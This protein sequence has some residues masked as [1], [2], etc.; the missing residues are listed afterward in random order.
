MPHSAAGMRVEPPVSV[1]MVISPMPSAQ[2]TAPPEDEPPG[3]RLRSAGLPGVPKCGLAPTPE[4]ANSVMLVLATITAPASRRRLTAGASAA[5]GLPRLR[6]HRRACARHL[7][8]DI[9][10]ILDGDDRAV[11]RTEL[12]AGLCARVGGVGSGARGVGIDGETGSL[13]FAGRISDAG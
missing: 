13:A 2:A 8:R 12:L 1:P 3:M 11:E 10:Q 6:Q 4:N 9:E 7:A 5:A